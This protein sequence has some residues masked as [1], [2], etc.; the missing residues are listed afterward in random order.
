LLLI[1]LLTV[2]VPIVVGRTRPV[3]LPIVVGEILTGVAICQSGLDLVQPGP[4]L[5]FLSELGFTF[6][7]FLSGLEASVGTLSA[8][9]EGTDQRPWTRRP[10][11]LAVVSFLGTL[12][13][14]LGNSLVLGI[15]REGEILVPMVIPCYSKEI[16]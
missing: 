12:L 15:R 8:A 1:I 11:F 16:S 5:I 9:A 6:L 4:T 14:A 10:I 3:H 7:M 13:L 2:V